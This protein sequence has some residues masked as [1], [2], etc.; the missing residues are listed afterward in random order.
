MYKKKIWQFCIVLAGLS[1][2]FNSVIGGDKLALNHLTDAE[3]KVIINKATE[4]PFVGI[5]VNHKEEGVYLCKQ[6]NTPLYRSSDKFDS[7]CGWPSFDDEI[8][9]AVKRIPDKDDERTEIICATCGAHLGHVFTGEW[10][11]DK[12]TRHCV[13]SISLIFKPK[14]EPTMENIAYFAGGC[15]WGTEFLFQELEGVLD[16]KVGYMGGKNENPTYK[17]VCSGKTGHYEAVKVTYDTDK[18]DYETLARYF[19]EIHDPTQEDGQGPDIGEQYESVIFCANEEE[20]QTVKQLIDQL[21]KKGYHVATQ[22]KG[23]ATF[24]EAEE[25]HQDYYKKT[26]KYP[27]CHIYTNRF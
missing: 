23:P 14:E 19:F 16:T 18:L 4:P 24:W 2:L 6:C 11:T 8:A 5:Y 21:E 20:K 1:G 9:G 7:Q 3:K 10:F 15:F 22:I 17:E 25:Y 13:N 12:N 27:Y 26:G